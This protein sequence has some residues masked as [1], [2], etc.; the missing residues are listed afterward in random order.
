VPLCYLTSIQVGG[1]TEGYLKRN[2][3]LIIEGYGIMKGEMRQ[4][5]PKRFH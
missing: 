3:K 5:R 2:S 1:S 4:K